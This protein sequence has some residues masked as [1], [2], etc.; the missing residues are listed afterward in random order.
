MHD[1]L[2]SLQVYS[3]KRLTMRLYLHEA[4]REELEKGLERVYKEAA[5]ASDMETGEDPAVQLVVRKFEQLA[6]LRQVTP[7]VLVQTLLVQWPDTFVSLPT[8]SEWLDQQLHEETRKTVLDIQ[9]R[10]T[11]L[12]NSG[13]AELRDVLGNRN[14]TWLANN[15]QFQQ[16][17]LDALASMRPQSD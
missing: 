4:S 10:L 17:V 6:S 8:M 9:L 16:S 13:L 11:N 12:E 1:T 2:F 3:S 7:A 14:V 15:V 5:A